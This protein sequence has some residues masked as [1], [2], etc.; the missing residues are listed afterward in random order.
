[1]DTT[2]YNTGILVCLALLP[3]LTLGAASTNY[4]IDFDVLDGGG[5]AAVSPQYQLRASSQHAQALGETAS[6]GHRLHGGLVS[7]LDQDGDGIHDPF[8]NC[9]LLVNPDQ[10]DFD[11]DGLGNACDPWPNNVDGDGDGLVDGTDGVVSVSVYPS[12]IDA[13]GDG[14]VDGEQDNGTNASLADT[15]GDGFTDGLE[16]Y[17]GS[18]P[19][20]DTD[21]PANGDVNED[22]EVNVLDVMLVTR[23]ILNRALLDADQQV[24]ADVA[25]V[26][27][28][29]IPDPDGDI[30]AGDLL[31]IEQW[32]VQP[33]LP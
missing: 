8:D 6:A 22:G 12:G 14:F 4:R 15:D 25:P 30:N 23:H 16:V 20:L 9:P 10:S 21:T 11:A 18:D 29:G 13:N 32:A 19:L 2:H 3:G 1:M 7:L 31:R 5:G 27:E 28:Q 33:M 24:R 17:F 26:D